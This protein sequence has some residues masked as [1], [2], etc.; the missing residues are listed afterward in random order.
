MSDEN[1]GAESVPDEWRK[2]KDNI[3]KNKLDSSEPLIVSEDQAK[4]VGDDRVVPR[5]WRRASLPTEIGGKQ[6]DVEVAG[7]SPPSNPDPIEWKNHKENIGKRADSFSSGVVDEDQAKLVKDHRVVPKEWRRASMTPT[8]AAGSEG[9]FE[10]Q[11]KDSTPQEWRR[12]SVQALPASEHD[13]L[14]R[15]PSH[16]FQREEEKVKKK[17]GLESVPDSW[18]GNTQSMRKLSV[19]SEGKS[20]GGSTSDGQDELVET[21][22]AKQFFN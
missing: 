14:G 2:N 13:N 21:N 20:E 22:E 19:N 18:V 15:R 12:A 1:N 10:P 4:L 8:A 7:T 11:R 3:A 5:E 9:K 16:I 6:V 17:I